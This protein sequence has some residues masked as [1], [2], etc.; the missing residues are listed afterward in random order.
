[1]LGG[2]YSHRGLDYGRFVGRGTLFGNLEV[3]HDLLPFGDLGA[4]TL[5]GFLDVG[6]VFDEDF[7]L[8]TEDLKVGG[9]GGFAIRV[10]RSSV[11]TFN[12]AGGPDGF[13]FSLGNGWMF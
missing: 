11:L 2:Q 12:F 1:V 8:T 13:Q 5:L 7:R 4:V 3:R 6:R 9:G 10:L